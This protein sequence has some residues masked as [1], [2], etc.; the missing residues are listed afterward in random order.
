MSNWVST[1]EDEG[2]LVNRRH[3]L[4]PAFYWQFLA[5]RWA[6]ILIPFVIISTAGLLFAIL[7]PSTY[8]AEGKL[9]V[10]PQQISM[11]LVRPT[12]TSAAQDRLQI[13][14]QRTMTRENLAQIA[15]VYDLF[16]AQRQGLP[17]NELVDRIRKQIKINVID[18]AP[19]FGQRSRG[20]NPPIIFSVGFEYTDPVIAQKV[21]ED[22]IRRLISEDIRDRTE[23]AS[24]TTVFMTEEFKKLQLENEQ[25]DNKVSELRA[26]LRKSA[27]SETEKSELNQLTQLR[28][29]YAQKSALYSE[30]HPVLKSLKAQLDMLERAKART[31][32]IDAESAATLEAYVA[33]QEVARK[34]LDQ[35]AAK[36]NSAKA[37]ESLE[38]NQQSEKLEIVEAPPVPQLPIRP[39]RL[40]IIV[41][42]LFVGLAVG[43][44]FAYLADAFDTGIRYERDLAGLIDPRLVSAI[45]V[46]ASP[47]HRRQRFSVAVLAAVL[48]VAAGV[49]ATASSEMFLPPLKDLLTKTRASLLP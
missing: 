34:T 24:G 29:E 44:G 39:N 6:R 1:A 14:Q 30:Q 9:L 33:R 20:V 46:I 36:M 43:I 35:A 15:D 28:D 13:I 40:R 23:R 27:A 45:P 8:F 3:L 5:R 37:G 17:T 22:L 4:K 18:P 2:D 10:R 19:E 47:R 7:Q 25:L 12:V 48:V 38:K 11:D 26:S 21:A 31:K 16:P 42:T 32:S 49:A 41:T